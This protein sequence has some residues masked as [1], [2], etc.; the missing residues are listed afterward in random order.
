[1]N[2]QNEVSPSA[3]VRRPTSATRQSG[4]NSSSI[5][6]IKSNT[7]TQRASESLQ[8]NGLHMI[9]GQD[10]LPS[11]SDRISSAGT[12]VKSAQQRIVSASNKSRAGLPPIVKSSK[13]IAP[14]ESNFDD[15][16]DGFGGEDMFKK[17]VTKL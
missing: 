16:G 9:S 14:S 12:R 1:M 10:R 7:R 5:A 15:F 11:A 13:H 2:I 8:Q 4:L 17:Y 3:E 6:G